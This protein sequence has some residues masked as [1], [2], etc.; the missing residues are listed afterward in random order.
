[1]HVNSYTSHP[2][3]MNVDIR[4]AMKSMCWLVLYV[5]YCPFWLSAFTA[6]A[7]QQQ[8][9][10]VSQNTRSAATSEKVQRTDPSALKSQTSQ[11]WWKLTAGHG[12]IADLSGW[13]GLPPSQGRGTEGRATA[14]CGIWASQQKSR[15]SCLRFFKAESIAHQLLQFD[16]NVLKVDWFVFKWPLGGTSPKELTPRPGR[17]RSRP[18][19]APA[20]REE[21]RADPRGRGFAPAAE[22]TPHLREERAPAPYSAS[23]V[24]LKHAVWKT[25]GLLRLKF[26]KFCWHLH[27]Q[28]LMFVDVLGHTMTLRKQMLGYWYGKWDWNYSAKGAE[29][30]A[31]ATPHPSSLTKSAGASPRVQ[32]PRW[33][34]CTVGWVITLSV[35]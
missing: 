11:D 18:F 23:G 30:P 16:F 12:W 3:K 31:G 13:F 4:H 17:P 5:L 34:R 14:I 26:G 24:Q 19:S 28:M 6:G 8:P 22:P 35:R 1:M 33:T 25:N 15:A 20:R 9:S 29:L 2:T 21:P 7:T 32:L 27:D 10:L